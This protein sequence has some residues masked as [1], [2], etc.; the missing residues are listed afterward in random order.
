MSDDAVQLKPK[1]LPSF[2][3]PPVVEVVCGLQFSPIPEWLT[4]HYG[5]FWNEVLAQYPKCQDQPP[6]GRLKL[7]DFETPDE[8]SAGLLPPLRRVFLIDESDCYLMQLQQNRFLHNWRKLRAEND[9]PR[10]EAAYGRF[11]AQWSRFTG[12]LHSA[13]LSA[14]NIEAYEL[15]YVNLIT[16]PDAKFPRDIGKFLDFYRGFPL[17]SSGAYPRVLNLQIGWPLESETGKLSLSVKHGKENV[18]PAREVLIAEFSAKGTARRDGADMESWFKAA[19]EAI[20]CT[21][22]A[23]T[24]PSAHKGWEIE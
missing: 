1:R 8:L 9:Y 10:F 23:L 4:S 20:V 6:L 7:E 3:R 15:T 17:A 13:R 14:P 5:L 12:F 18:E 19:H 24:T 11:V 21:F 22:E 2:K 16:A